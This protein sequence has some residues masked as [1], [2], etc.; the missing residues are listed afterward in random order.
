MSGAFEK[1]LGELNVAA[2]DGETLAKSLTQGG[3]SGQAGGA[4]GE[5]GE[6]GAG[7]AAGAGGA[8]G[9]GEGAGGEATLGKALKITLENGEEVEAIDGTELVKSLSARMDST[10][11]S[12]Q[13]AFGDLL[14]IVKGQASMIKSL[15]DQV[16]SLRGEGRGRKTML[17]IHDK[18]GSQASA[19]AAGGAGGEVLAKG[20]SGEGITAGEFMAKSEAAWKSGAIT[21]KDFTTIDV[22]LRGGAEI[23]TDLISKVVQAKA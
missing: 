8:G 12:L 2:Q 1:L 21:G 4:G 13:K 10:D 19:A 6:G 3:E 18:N 23:P 17:A 14:G 22:C 16:T 15:S 7:G 9:A 5:G 11:A 20:G